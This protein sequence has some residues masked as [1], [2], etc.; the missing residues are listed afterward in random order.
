[1]VLILLAVFLCFNQVGELANIASR[2]TDFGTIYH[3]SE[4]LYAGGD[5]YAATDNAYFYPP[6]L[7]VL[8]GPVTW[9][10]IAPASLLFFALKFVMLIW[11]LVA[12]DRLVGGDG[13]TGGRR[14]LFVLGLVFV[15]SRF[16]M[17]DLQYGNTNVVIMFLMIAAISWDRDDRPW[18][19]GLV[20]ALAVSIKIV[21]VFLCL[22]FLVLRRWRTLVY[23]SVGMAL[24]NLLPWLF[25]QGHW[26]ATW[27]AYFDAGVAAKLSQ[28]LAQ[29]DNQSLWGLLNRKFPTQPLADLRL[30]WFLVS[31]ALGLWAGWVTWAA[32]RKGPLAL[33]AAASLYFLVGLMVSPGSWVVHYTAVLLPMVVLW[34]LAL[35]DRAPGRGAWPLFALTNIAFTVSGWSRPTVHASI[36]QSWFVLAAILL[37]VGLG[38][39]VLATPRFS[40]EPRETD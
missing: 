6:L 35:S 22:H 20:L 36:T 3:A 9:L 24:L 2:V 10:P 12:C 26:L 8:F 7:A 27:N 33:T 40:G 38:A 5:P 4:A 39:W 17:A 21:P 29:P 16:W 18:A 1:V 19:A 32:R 15:A 25:L 34:T 31:G 30:G 23:F 28:R 37:L 14:T 11:T 13:F